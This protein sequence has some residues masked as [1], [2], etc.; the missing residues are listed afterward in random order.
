MSYFIYEYIVRYIGIRYTSSIEGI[1]QWLD[2]EK[3]KGIW[4]DFNRKKE[5]IKK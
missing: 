2:E 3:D 5:F 4:E 1:S